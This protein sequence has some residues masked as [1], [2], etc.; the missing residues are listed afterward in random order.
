MNQDTNIRMLLQTKL[1]RPPLGDYIIDRPHLTERLEQ[2]VKRKFTL[3]TAPAG[4]GKSTLVISWLESCPHQAAWLSLDETDNDLTRFLAYVVAAIQTI[5]PNSLLQTHSLLRASQNVPSEFL[6][7]TLI[8]EIGAIDDAFILVLDDYHHL[9]DETIHQVMGKFIDHMPTQMQLVIVSR[10]TP[11]FPIPRLRGRGKLSQIH[12]YDLCFSVAE[13][14]AFLSRFLGA[15]PSADIV[16]MLTER[17]EG[18]IAGLRLAALSMRYHTDQRA[19]VDT[20]HGTNRYIMEYL[21]D[22]ILSYQPP[23]IQQFLLKTAILDR[24]CASL[25]DA[26]TQQPGSCQAY[27]EWL[28]QA[29][30]LIIPLDQENCWYRYHHLFR[31][32]LGHKLRVEFSQ[33]EVAALHTSAGEWLAGHG[34]IEEAVRHLLAAGDISGAAQ[35]VDDNRHSL[36]NRDDHRTLER[37]LALLPEEQ[38][39]QRPGLLLARAW[40]WNILYKLRAIPPLLQA[41]ETLLDDPSPALT[42]EAVQHLRAETDLL[43]GINLCWQGQG[44]A[45]FDHLQRAAPHL[46]PSNPYLRGQAINQFGLAAYMIGQWELAFEEISGWLQTELIPADQVTIRFLAIQGWNHFFS[47]ELLLAVQIAHQVATMAEANNYLNMQAWGEYF[48]GYIHYLWNDLDAATAYLSQAMNKRYQMHTRAAIDSMVLLTLTY[49]AS[50]QPERANETLK[51]LVEYAGQTQNSI[52]RVVAQACQARL[53]LWQGHPELARRWLHSK[54]MTVDLEGMVF[55]W[56]QPR[57]TYC[58]LLIAEGSAATLQEAAANLQTYLQVA[59]EGHNS[60]QMIQILTLQALVYRAQ[61]RLD[62]AL[63]ALERAVTLARPGGFILNFVEYGLPMAELLH[64]LAG[65]GVAPAYLEQILTAF[66]DSGFTNGDFQ[67][68]DK[69][70]DGRKYP[71]GASSKITDPLIE[72]LSRRE[73]EILELLAMRL[74]NQEIGDSLHISVPTVK[75]HIS[76]ICEKLEVKG[77]HVA[78]ARARALGILPI[79]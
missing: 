36:L 67:R 52:H 27:L 11:P 9:V 77:R 15:S 26:V 60:F 45:S 22:E 23:A 76:H 62:Q 56:Q 14:E 32:L 3:I 78:V 40:V 59:E 19:F 66:A 74:S 7:T 69:T 64:Q 38:I 63:A 16:A 41:A 31:D 17:T 49:Q 73:Q 35:L 53:L 18:W 72:P 28:Q 24:F 71:E 55:W 50:S 44:Q 61:G 4:Y 33:Q 29:N 10:E 68:P 70:S 46:A 75:T 25:C 58:R 30:V 39:K 20:F 57:F 79:K 13:T 6:A 48:L 1:N 43:R 34:F 54:E 5:F 2:G 42:P 12:S 37:W 21:L 8:N 47:A 65:R 51:L